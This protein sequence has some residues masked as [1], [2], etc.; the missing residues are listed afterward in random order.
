MAAMN[1]ATNQF[2]RLNTAKQHR[3]QEKSCWLA[4]RSLM[5]H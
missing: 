2:I 1:A 4:T 3:V 5:P